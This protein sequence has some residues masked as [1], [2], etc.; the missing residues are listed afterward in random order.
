MINSDATFTSE[1]ISVDRKNNFSSKEDILAAE[2]PL[3]IK[4]VFGNKNERIEL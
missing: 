4:I 1:I 2:E 3:E